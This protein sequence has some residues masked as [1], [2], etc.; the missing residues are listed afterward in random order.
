MEHPSSNNNS[1][2]DEKNIK[3]TN[4]DDGAKPAVEKKPRGRVPTMKW[5]AYI[6]TLDFTLRPIIVQTVKP[7]AATTN[8]SYRDFSKVPPPPGYN[9]PKSIQEM[10]FSQRVHDM[11]SQPR[12]ESTITWMPHGRAFRVVVP[13]SFESELCPRYFQHNRYSSFLR[14]LNKHGFKHL[15]K[16]DDRNCKRK[17]SKRNETCAL[18]LKQAG[19]DVCLLLFFRVSLQVIIMSSCYEVAFISVNLCQE[20]KMRGDWT[21]VGCTDIRKRRTR[22]HRA[23][24]VA[25]PDNEPNF[26]MIHDIFPIDDPA[27]PTTTAT[28]TTTPSSSLAFVASTPLSTVGLSSPPQPPSANETKGSSKEDTKP[29]AV[30][31]EITTTATETTT[32]EIRQHHLL[33]QQ[34]LAGNAPPTV[35]SAPSP[36]LPTFIPGQT[37]AQFHQS[38]TPKTAT[39]STTLQLSNHHQVLFPGGSSVAVIQQHQQPRGS[40]S[41]TL[42]EASSSAPS[43]PIAGGQHIPHGI[44]PTIA[45]SIIAS[46]QGVTDPPSMMSTSTATSQQQQQQGSDP[47][48]LSSLLS[49]VPALNSR[50][51]TP[52]Q[53]QQQQHAFSNSPAELSSVLQLLSSIDSRGAN[54]PA[55]TEIS[56][57]QPGGGGVSMDLPSVLSLLT[58]VNLQDSGQLLL[59]LTVLLQG[60]DLWGQDA[61]RLASVLALMLSQYNQ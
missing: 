50:N 51:T 26:Y 58:S 14:D 27:K 28:N 48:L 41:T 18:F 19:T 33:Q 15:T 4:K 59:L 40:L 12:Y 43:L 46:F 47:A 6:K 11:L 2:N 22:L 52:Q 9:P 7:K 23:W 21:Q 45:S 37:T 10:T 38:S 60:P 24:L 31:H 53:Q 39:N 34:R 55:A 3:H 35:A 42:D 54:L 61:S 13:K 20:Q 56:Q 17:T 36:L 1:N 5:K 44:S 8:H 32:M 49:I 16:G 25:H 57:R 29:A 30:P